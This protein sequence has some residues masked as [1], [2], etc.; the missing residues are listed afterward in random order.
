MNR[1][2]KEPVLVYTPAVPAVPATPAYCYTQLVFAGYAEPEGVAVGGV[3]SSSGQIP[4]LDANGKVSY[5]GPGKGGGS[6]GG[7]SGRKPIYRDVITCVAAKPG[8][9]GVPAKLDRFA[10]IGWNAGARSVKPLPQAG[11]FQCI[12]PRSLAGVVVGLSD[13]RFDHGYSH[14]SHAVAF[15]ESGMMPIRHGEPLAPSVALVPG[16]VVRFERFRG[17]ITVYVDGVL[18]HAFAEPLAGLAFADVT[19]YSL[20]D[21]VDDP[22]IGAL[23]VGISGVAPAWRGTLAQNAYCFIEGAAPA[24]VMDASSRSLLSV[25]GLAPAAIGYIGS[26]TFCGITARAPVPV[27]GIRSGA[28]EADLCGIFG[29][30][31]VPR[32]SMLSTAGVLS[33]VEGWAPA[34]QGYVSS[35]PY[36]GIGGAWGVAYSM[37]AWQPYLPEN[38]SDGGDLVYAADF[39]HLA[40]VVMF[41][42]HDGIRIADSLDLVLLVNLEAYEYLGIGDQVTLGGVIQLLAMERV[43]VNSSA[44]AARQE[45][46]QYAVNV[47]TGALTTYQ[48]FGFTQFARAGGETYA[49]RPD[50][51]YCL[52]G[53]TDNGETLRAMIDFGASDYGTAQGKRIAHVYAGVTTD[54]EV[55][56]RVIPDD[57]AERCYRAVGNSPEFRAPVAKGLKARHWRVRLEVT[58][59]T[60]LD[61]DNI[62]VELGVSQRRLGKVRR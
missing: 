60:Y 39:G 2:Q 4:Y 28:P 48:N 47:L 62:E 45:A 29:H 46:L 56:V 11:Y 49:I 35:G 20:A 57:G 12:L 9:P 34:A 8:K 13:G 50:G 52:R 33:S 3:G 23:P 30:G 18:F 44:R 38:V 17:R 37:T 27:L 41:I 36:C 7:G 1:L 53:D 54:G 16:A 43:A 31:P 55:Y 15:R 26:R 14:A 59:A 51:L 61:V 19:L 58:D 22:E 24:G 10:S 6:V 32:V 42:V 5:I 21:F 40:N 25:S